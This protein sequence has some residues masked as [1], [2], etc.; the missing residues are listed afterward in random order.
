M[1]QDVLST[2][3]CHLIELENQVQCMMESY[4]ALNKTV[5]VSKIAS[6]CEICSGPH[7]TQYCMENPEQA[8]VDYAS[9]KHYEQ[10]TSQKLESRL[11]PSNPSKKS[12]FVG[13][14]RDLKV[15]IGDFPNECDFMVLEDT[16]SVIDH[17][18]G[19][20]VFGKP[21]KKD[22][23]LAYDKEEG[24]ITFEKYD[25]KVTFKMPHKMEMFR[26]VFPKD[27]NT[28]FIPSFV[29]DN[30][31]YHGKVYYMNSLIIGP[32]YKQDE[33]VSKEIQH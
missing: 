8:F 2:S 16:T 18:L 20:V 10:I 29:L 27:M 31:N 30:K 15:F 1:P 5:Q 14:V 7:D 12:N 11:K 6:S 17:D 22:F 25:E 19:E 9:S 13:R 28:D 4:L 33:S 26:H 24:T 21:F 23:G 3:D 32:E